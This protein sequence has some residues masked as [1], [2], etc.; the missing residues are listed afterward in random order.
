MDRSVFSL[1]E[2]LLH[3]DFM[4]WVPGVDHA[5]QTVYDI[6]YGRVLIAFQIAYG[7][8][9]CS[10]AASSTNSAP[11]KAMPSPSSS[12]DARQ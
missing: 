1:I 8:G 5:H 12:G 4:G 7:V 6:N 11:R 2:P 3:L 10:P 9:S